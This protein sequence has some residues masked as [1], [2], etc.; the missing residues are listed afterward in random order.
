[1][2][3]ILSSAVPYSLEMVALKRIPAYRYGVLMSADP[4]IAAIV[5][6]LML[7]EHLSS[8]QCLAIALV[9]TASVGSVL[10]TAN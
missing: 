4:A 8:L 2:I 3:A 7:A 5:G 10:A 9:T 1:V 6:R